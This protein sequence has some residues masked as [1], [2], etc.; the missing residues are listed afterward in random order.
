MRNIIGEFIVLLTVVYSVKEL[1]RTIKTPK[2]DYHIPLL[3]VIFLFGNPKY[4]VFT[5]N[6]QR[7]IYNLMLIS[8]LLLVGYLFCLQYLYG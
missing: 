8:Y 1:Y 2:S 3:M 7:I 6:K 4:N 5:K